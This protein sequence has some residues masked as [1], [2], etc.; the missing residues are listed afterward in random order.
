M[1]LPLYICLS[2]PA[3]CRPPT[4]RLQA[5]LCLPPQRSC[6]FVILSL[7]HPTLHSGITFLLLPCSPCR[8]TLRNHFL[9]ST[10]VARL[11][12]HP[13]VR[14]PLRSTTLDGNGTVAYAKMSSTINTNAN[15][16]SGMWENKRSVSP[17]A[18]PFALG[19]T[20]GNDITRSTARGWTSGKTEVSALRMLSSRFRDWLEIWLFCD[21][22]RKSKRSPSFGH[23]NLVFYLK[24]FK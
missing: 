5:L 17:V 19:R 8:H 15:D 10:P 13:A 12:D 6:R 7:G 3:I 20:I 1:E 18:K 2:G 4:M 24:Y 21:S 9:H 16:I 14:L 11:Q 22:V 23:L